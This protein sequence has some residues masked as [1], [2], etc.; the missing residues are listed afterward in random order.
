MLSNWLEDFANRFVK[1]LVGFSTETT[2]LVVKHWP[3]TQQTGRSAIAVEKKASDYVNDIWSI[4]DYARDVVRPADYSKTILPFAA[5]RRFEYDKE[6]RAL[7]KK[8]GPQ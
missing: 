6:M 3:G 4:A 7:P 1:P 5:P 8:P 2:G